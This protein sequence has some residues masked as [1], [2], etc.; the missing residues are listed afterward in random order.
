MADNPRNLTS[1]QIQGRIRQWKKALGSGGLTRKERA[2][3]YARMQD[4]AAEL[5]ARGEEMLREE[6]NDGKSTS[7]D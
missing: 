2:Q 5:L 3:F 1:A 6:D 7:D 4:F